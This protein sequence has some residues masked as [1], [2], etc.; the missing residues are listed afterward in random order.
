MR[1]SRMPEP[2][3]RKLYIKP[4]HGWEVLRDGDWRGLKMHPNVDAATYE[5]LQEIRESGITTEILLMNDNDKVTV[6]WVVTPYMER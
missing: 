6:R 2:T 3:I 5:A 4:Q 1:R